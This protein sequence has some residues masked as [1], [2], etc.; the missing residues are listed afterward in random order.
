MREY[1]CVRATCSSFVRSCDTKRK[2]KTFFKT[3]RNK[4][5]RNVGLKSKFDMLIFNLSIEY[6]NILMTSLFSSR[7]ERNV[8]DVRIIGSVF[9]DN[10]QE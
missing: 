10:A 7:K 5:S 6:N 9:Y 4:E 8:Y 1:A 3:M 2:K